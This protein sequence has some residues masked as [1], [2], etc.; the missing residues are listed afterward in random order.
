MELVPRVGGGGTEENGGEGRGG[1][2]S[3]VLETLLG[4]KRVGGVSNL[5]ESDG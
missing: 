2:E 1:Q 5:E 3:E 4:V